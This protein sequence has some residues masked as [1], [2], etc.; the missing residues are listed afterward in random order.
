MRLRRYLGGTVLA[1]IGAGLAIG[2][3]GLLAGAIT[4]GTWV[5]VTGAYAIAIGG[6][7]VG[8]LGVPDLT[9]RVAIGCS[10]GFGAII[11]AS[12]A[13]GAL[14]RTSLITGVAVVGLVA[15]VFGGLALGGPL[16]ASIVLLG[17]VALVG[18]AL[19]RYERVALGLVKGDHDGRG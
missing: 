6:L 16:G 10:I 1:T 7:L 8:L 12:R 19:H 14:V 5:L 3:A 2:P 11:V 18:Y 13:S 4:G 9:G 15:I 17:T